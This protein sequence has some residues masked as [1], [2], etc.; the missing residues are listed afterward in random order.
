MSPH[1]GLA[2]HYEASAC[3]LVFVDSI[4]RGEIVF[5][6]SILRGET[7]FVDSILRG[8]MTFAN[9][10]LTNAAL[11]TALESVWC[12]THVCVSVCIY[13]YTHISMF[14]CICKCTYMTNAAFTTALDSVWCNTHL[15]M[16]VCIYIYI[17]VCICVM[18][19]H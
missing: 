2:V 11:T 5:V 15:Y 12:N 4:L 19:P 13:I 16:S 7:V 18:M 17:C 8:E 1:V 9:L 10:Y 3:Q 14:K 6:D